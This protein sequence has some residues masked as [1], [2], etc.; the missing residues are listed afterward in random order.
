MKH[1]KSSKTRW[2]ALGGLAVAGV[3]YAAT[4]ITIGEPFSL[5]SGDNGHKPKIQRAGD[6]TLVVV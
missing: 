3:A 2:L 5:S 1:S 4:Q 6:G